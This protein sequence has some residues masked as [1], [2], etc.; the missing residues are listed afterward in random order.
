MGAPDE[1][2]DSDT[3]M[4]VGVTPRAEIE[5]DPPVRAMIRKGAALRIIRSRAEEKRAS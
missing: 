3:P 2:N 4:L 5:A 1:R